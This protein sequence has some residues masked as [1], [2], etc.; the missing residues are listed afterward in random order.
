MIYRQF[1][2]G[3]APKKGYGFAYQSSDIPSCVANMLHLRDIKSRPSGAS[4]LEIYSIRNDDGA[5]IP[6]LVCTKEAGSGAAEQ[7]Y[8]H[9]LVGEAESAV[10]LSAQ[11]GVLVADNF[12]DLYSF[13]SLEEKKQKGEPFQP[14]S[15]EPSGYT[16]IQAVFGGE[17]EGLLACYLWKLCEKL[18]SRPACVLL[19]TDNADGQVAYARSRLLPLLPEKVKKDIGMV[20]GATP[21]LLREFPTAAGCLFLGSA[22]KDSV[23]FH[24]AEGTVSVSDKDLAEAEK[25]LGKK[26]AL[27]QYPAHFAEIS[28]DSAELRGNFRLAVRLM[29]LEMAVGRQSLA[30]RCILYDEAYLSLR[31]AMSIPAE[32][33]DT[34]AAKS[35]ALWK[36]LGSSSLDY[37]AIAKE[38]LSRHISVLLDVCENGGDEYLKADCL[39]WLKRMNISEAQEEV[40]L[41][42]FA[43]R[44]RSDQAYC[45]VIRKRV[46]EKPELI[47]LIA[48]MRARLPSPC[49]KDGQ[50]SFDHRLLS[51][52]EDRPS[53]YRE[54]GPEK[55]LELAKR[56]CLQPEEKKNLIDEIT[57]TFLADDAA[58]YDLAKAMRASQSEA[59]CRYA[60]DVQEKLADLRHDALKAQRSAKTIKDYLEAAPEAASEDALIDVL[61]AFQNLSE[62]AQSQIQDE[63]ISYIVKCADSEVRNDQKVL[64]VFGA[65]SDK[66]GIVRLLNEYFRYDISKYQDTATGVWNSTREDEIREYV[67]KQVADRHGVL[68]EI[69]EYYRTGM[70]EVRKRYSDK[71]TDKQLWQAAMDPEDSPEANDVYR[72]TLRGLS[73]IHDVETWEK[74]QQMSDDPF[75]SK[76]WE[77][78]SAE[79]PICML[80][81]WNKKDTREGMRIVNF[82]EQKGGDGVRQAAVEC[83]IHK[84]DEITKPLSLVDALLALGTDNCWERAM[85]EANPKKEDYP[86][87]LHRAQWLLH[88]LDCNGANESVRASFVQYFHAH[89]QPVTRY[90]K[91][92]P[93]A[94]EPVDPVQALADV[95]NELL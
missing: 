78:A 42:A 91:K 14:I 68:A 55:C 82:V 72:L 54:N 95:R 48:K 88:T 25:E 74:L 92:V 93:Q 73:A 36:E 76:V 22:P 51:C 75:F 81:R 21:A 85:G 84:D 37:H 5:Y 80:V 10:D 45:D 26:L 89:Y 90:Y 32:R 38:N 57:Q 43:E 86:Y 16:A 60:D 50:E 77:K 52:V 94:L 29:E 56:L 1:A 70:Q 4:V 23:V 6:V 33:L 3:R 12:L 11:L 30:E 67:R 87:I 58:L 13:W 59:L 41:E 31:G 69:I 8:T 47:F 34:L 71:R 40:L 19:G 62:E 7:C 65:R 61:D 46:A 83:G 35:A 79:N 27:Q 39:D 18:A 24:I 49:D 2:T 9:I 63:V 15:I 64:Q 44:K 28:G 66:K 17:T 53:L 20:F